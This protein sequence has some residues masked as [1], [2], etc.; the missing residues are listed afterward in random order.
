M[1]TFLVSIVSFVSL[2]SIM[3]E[4]ILDT[5]NELFL[6]YG[7]KSVTMDEIAHNLSISKKTIY[8]FY[9]TKTELVEAC[10]FKIFNQ[11]SVGIDAICALK[12]NPIEE[13]FD[14]KDFV[15]DN[16][17][18][19]KTSPQFQLKKYYP[20]LFHT[21]QK[22][23][24]EIM[25]VCVKE[26]LERGIES[27]DFRKD[28]DIDFI[29]RIY[30]SGVLS[31]KDIELFPTGKNDMASLMRDYLNYHIRAIATSKGV[32]KLETLLKIDNL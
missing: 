3:R 30:F 27:G 15:T 17:K 11:I 18:G 20:V 2:L 14:I 26:N 7:F 31:V 22:K 5:A 4:K 28:I 6:N 32:E 1:E 9:K 24:F 23:Q 19:E 29:S 21:M 10:V 8:T 25:E 13:M 16:L 12:K